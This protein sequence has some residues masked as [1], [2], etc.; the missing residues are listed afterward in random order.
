MT[1]MC[2]SRHHWQFKK[3]YHIIDSRKS[4]NENDGSLS[5]HQ[6]VEKCES[7]FSLLQQNPLSIFRDTVEN[8]ISYSKRNVSEFQ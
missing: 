1:S 5:I 2:Y 8:R 3:R 4:L 7:S 6:A